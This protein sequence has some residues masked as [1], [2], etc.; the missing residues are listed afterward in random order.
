MR[1]G[2]WSFEVEEGSPGD[3][4][5]VRCKREGAVQS[6][7]EALDLG[8]EGYREPVDDDGWGWGVL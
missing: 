8:G 6:D 4:F 1:V 3:V 5:N 7:A 2:V